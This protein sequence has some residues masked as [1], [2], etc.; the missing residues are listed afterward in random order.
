MGKKACYG[1]IVAGVAANSIAAEVGITPGDCILAVDGQ[2]MEDLIDYKFLTST[3]SLLLSVRKP[4]GDEWEIEIEKDYDE[5]LGIEFTT[6]T[7]NVMRHCTNRCIFCFID[8]NPPG[9]RESLYEYDDDYRLSFLYGQFVT[10]TNL[11]ES[12]WQRIARLHLSPLYVSVH[13]MEPELRVRML[14]SPQAAKIVEHLRFFK[15]HGIQVHV[16][17]VLCPEVNDAEHLTYTITQLADFY[18]TVQSVAIVP[19]GITQFRTE[20]PALRPLNKEEACRLVESVGQWQKTYAEA[21]GT[22]FVWLAD[23]IY[24]QHDLPIPERLSYENLPQV[25]NGVGLTRLFL[26]EAQAALSAIPNPVWV[27][28]SVSIITG[29]LGAKVLHGLVEQLQSLGAP[30]RMYSVSNAFFGESITATGLVTAGDIIDQLVGRLLGDEVVIP[31]VM[32]RR[33]GASVFL[34]GKTI[35]QL[36]SALGVPVRVLVGA[37]ELIEHMLIK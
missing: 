19:A 36:E 26:L 30:V 11:R 6:A 12:D 37:K 35:T 1:A 8:Q 10:L 13:T 14:R 32:V 5:D 34:D 29:V 7:F 16:Q 31:E 20:L 9:L 24:V 18:P 22:R 4:D 15:E 17:V 23:E 3:E 27:D 25:E 28:K 33:Q 2:S 21:L